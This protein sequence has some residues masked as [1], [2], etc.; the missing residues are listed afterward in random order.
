M[1]VTVKKISLAILFSLSA[2]TGTA[3]AQSDQGI[4]MIAD[5][6]KVS[7]IEQR[8]HNLQARQSNMQTELPM[9]KRNAHH[10]NKGNTHH[11]KSDMKHSKSAAQ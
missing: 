2:M 4:T 3:F 10:K 9:H 7:D 1:E 5:P 8:A 6:A 11:K